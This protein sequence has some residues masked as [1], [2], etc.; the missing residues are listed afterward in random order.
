[1]QMTSFMQFFASL[2]VLCVCD[3]ETEVK[4]GSANVCTALQSNM[5]ASV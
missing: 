5:V 2:T 1:M 3:R 4:R